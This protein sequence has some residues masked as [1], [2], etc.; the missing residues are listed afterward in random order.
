[1]TF[2]T[3]YGNVSESNGLYGIGQ[4]IPGST[5]F[6]WFIFKESVGQPAT[7]TGGSWN[8]DTNIGTAP[9]GWSSAS[10]NIPVNPVWFCIAFV[11]SRNPTVIVWSTP[12]KITAGSAAAAVD[13]SFAPTGAIASTNVQSA[14]SEVVTDLALSSGSSTIGYLPAGTGAVAT[15]IQAK[16][17]E[18]VSVLA[19]GAVG[20]GSTD[21]STAFANAITYLKSIGGG[22]L[23][24]PMPSVGYAINST[25]S[26]NA[27]HNIS[28]IADGTSAGLNSVPIIWNGANGGNPLYINISRD[29]SF[30]NFA[31]IAG[32][33]TIGIAI[34]IQNTGP[35][36]SNLSTHLIFNNIHIGA[37]TTAV[38][39]GGTSNNDLHTF[40]N[41]TIDGAG[42]YGYYIDNSQSKFI[43]IQ[44]GDIANKTY[45]IYC[46]NGSFQSY[47]TNF[48]QNTTDIFL[49]N[50]ND[51]ISIISPQSESANKFLDDTGTA[52][53]S[54]TINVIGGRLSTD[55]VGSDNIYIR[56]RKRGALNLIG[57]YIS[58]GIEQAAVKVFVQSS[59]AAGF[60]S[61]GNTY[62]NAT[63]WSGS[64]PVNTFGDMRVD[65]V[66]TGLIMPTKSP[67]IV[68]NYLSTSFTSSWTPDM[69]LSDAEVLNVNSTSAIA[70]N[71]PTNLSTGKQFNLTLSNIGVT[72]GTVT[73]NA[74]Y[75]MASFTNPA[76]GFRTT[77]R[78][79]Y[80]GT[81]C[82]EI[83]RATAIPN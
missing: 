1:M 28:I 65:S 39:F 69:N 40:N 48:S 29:N 8:F 36:G 10:P 60:N 11:D 63:P 64:A 47:T 73:W 46:F 23:I 21:N 41:V 70:I 83:S 49:N 34:D 50:P 20:N 55:N 31:I 27:V 38:N 67:L 33:G 43:N 54:W 74:I 35:S 2:G 15:T 13:I 24:L 76:N 22:N 42:T 9:T 4:L 53:G 16:L 14:I 82:Y 18:T 75:K 3:L 12:S 25:W 19:F 72:M 32:T 52:G 79:Q 66:G 6:E 7:P 81:N 37:A 58:T 57:N 26:L 78:F 51:A 61:F 5:Y 56:Y 59:A 30:S 77:I 44:G 62:P 17:R 80:D 45:G 71:A 68:A